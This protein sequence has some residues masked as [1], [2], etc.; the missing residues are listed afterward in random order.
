MVES[1][2]KMSVV[3]YFK[4]RIIFYIEMSPCMLQLIILKLVNDIQKQKGTLIILYFYVVPSIY[5]HIMCLLCCMLLK[6]S[7]SI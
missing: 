2:L 5:V 4:Y 6:V 1:D 7:F 3:R